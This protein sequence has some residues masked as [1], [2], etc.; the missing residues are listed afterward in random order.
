MHRVTYCVL[1]ALATNLTAAQI[2]KD[3]FVRTCATPPFRMVVP[4]VTHAPVINGQFDD[5][6]WTGAPRAA[7]FSVANAS[8]PA[9]QQ[10]VVRIVYD[11]EALYLL[12]CAE[13]DDVRAGAF[14][15][16]SS[17]VWQSDC[18][19]LFFSPTRSERNE[20]WFQYVTNADGAQ[21]D[22]LRKPKPGQSWN[23][24]GGWVAAG[25]RTEWGW[26]VEVKIPFAG[27]AVGT[28]EAGD[29]WSARLAREDY[30]QRRPFQLSSFTPSGG[31]FDS[32]LSVID[33]VFDRFDAQKFAAAHHVKP[34][35]SCLTGNAPSGLEHLNAAEAVRYTYREAGV[36]ADSFPF[37]IPFQERS[38]GE[39]KIVGGWLAASKGILTD[40]I[41][42]P[43]AGWPG[44]YVG[45]TGFDVLFDLGG[46]RVIDQVE[47]I[48]GSPVILNA[49]LYLKRQDGRFILTRA[50]VDRAE[51]DRNGLSEPK[52]QVPWMD[53][54]AT[55]RWV[56]VNLLPKGLPY[57]GLSEVRIW[58]RPLRADESPRDAMPLRQSVG[59]TRI[60]APRELP[61]ATPPEPLIFPAPQELTRHDGVYALGSPVRIAVPKTASPRTQMTA[62]VLRDELK[63]QYGIEATV[64]A[65]EAG[66]VKLG[67]DSKAVEHAEGYALEVS[68][69]G[70]TIRGRDE[71]GAFYGC[72]S[73]LQ[74]L[75]WT[76][77]GWAVPRMTVRDWPA[78]AY[79]YVLGRPVLNRDLIRAIGMT[80]MNYFDLGTVFPSEAEGRATADYVR[81]HQPMASRYFIRLNA[82]VAFNDAW[83]FDAKR[84]TERVAGEP[85]E[86]MGNGRRNPCPSEPA[87]WEAYFKQVDTVADVLDG[88][89]V[90]INMDE[91]QRSL[92]GA[93]W[94]VCD[95]CR[96]RNLTGHELLADTIAHIDDHL[97]SRGK[98]ILMINTPFL[99]TGI[100]NADDKVND[101]RKAAQLLAKKGRSSR[102][103]IYNA[104]GESELADLRKSGFSVL[105]WQSHV[106][107][108]LIAP[109][110]YEGYYLNLADGPFDVAQ[111]PGTAQ[112]AWSPDRLLPK[113]A[114]FDAAVEAHMARFAALID[115]RSSPSRAPGP[116]SFFTVD[117]AGVAN[118]SRV[119]EAPGDGKGWV[120]L[121]PE[122]D[123]R[124]LAAGRRTLDG[125][126]FEILD[127]RTTKGR[128]CVTVHSPGA[129]NAA[130]PTR[131]RIPVGRKA[132]SLL[133]LHTLSDRVSQEYMNKFELAGFYVMRYDDG[134]VAL[135][136]IKYGINAANWD[137]LETHWGYAPRGRA[138]RQARLAWEGQTMAGV[139]AAL[140]AAEWINPRPDRTITEV[141]LCGSWL[142]QQASPILL[143]MTGVASDEADRPGPAGP[144][145]G[146]LLDQ[147]PPVGEPIDLSGG[148]IESLT[149]YVAPDGTVLESDAEPYNLPGPVGADYPWN[150]VAHILF[151]NRYWPRYPGVTPT[152]QFTFPEARRLTGVNVSP[153]MRWE[154]KRIDSSGQARALAI[155]MSPDGKTWSKPIMAD[156]HYGELEG[157]RFV[158]FPEVE[159]PI[160]A[161]RISQDVPSFVQFYQPAR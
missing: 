60:D 150:T 118:R 77:R 153:Q 101:W 140:Y 69:K 104:S 138:L 78:K 89:F 158:P 82:M 124:A 8:A 74:S 51:F 16:D 100:S 148:S 17:R 45:V 86:T 139:T 35:M 154:Y 96:S 109:L 23:P 133:F 27:M 135:Y 113:S 6:C 152:I 132:R 79:R 30:G 85:E 34:G 141:W 92:D 149:R 88:E 147:T 111:I 97:K 22:D 119:D 156:M 129:Y 1:I 24:P 49:A 81:T 103:M 40:G 14:P 106:P 95:R 63:W 99:L 41:I 50:L 146:T 128:G 29:I 62:E 105:L 67:L 55:A 43:M 39:G 61:L 28:P 20:E 58:G 93:R 110:P 80:R 159:L 142:K 108:P 13:D 160:R 155:A 47:L 33:L 136:D 125:V 123:L 9:A 127:E 145:A 54:G 76:D 137:G 19:E 2:G 157:P 11:N 117:L 161:V 122:M 56:R 59:K 126:P 98:R 107:S 5:A 116:K 115:G 26:V 102:I 18:A 36:D 144:F 42:G 31:G 75:R 4:K 38:I 52:A 94:N 68:A 37:Y 151:S 91:M 87:M 46:D 112:L 114:P 73:L 21:Y 48:G 66:D 72:V 134:T 84:F 131:V 3:D 65:G 64:Q 143:A 32:V 12:V 15:H 83:R 71:A 120:D 10:T 57:P 25:G 70:V 44:H 130:L 7:G 121:G 53:I 90:N